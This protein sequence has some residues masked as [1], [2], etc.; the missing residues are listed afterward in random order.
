MKQQ[1][2]N[3]STNKT[4]KRS[5]PTL[6]TLSA[7]I[8]ILLTGCASVD[9]KEESI[10]DILA[11]ENAVIVKVQAERAQPVVQQGVSQSES[12]KTSE[13]HLNDALQGLLKANE[14]ITTKLIKQDEEEIKNERIFD[15]G[16]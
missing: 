6:L 8:Q 14:V 12:L 7:T 4:L 15:R 5:I 2:F 3:T 9:R 16:R 11:K 13:A 10:S 1:K